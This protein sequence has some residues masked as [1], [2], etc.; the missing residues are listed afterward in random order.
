L[1][2]AVNKAI[3]DCKASLDK[4]GCTGGTMNT[5]R[6]ARF[7]AEREPERQIQEGILDE[8]GGEPLDGSGFEDETSERGFEERG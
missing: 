2:T 1:T 3:I 7:L 5:P 6:A 8:L 4:L